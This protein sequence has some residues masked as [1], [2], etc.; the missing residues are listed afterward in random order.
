MAE[1]LWVLA[2]VAVFSGWHWSR[3]E[4][5][6][7]AASELALL[8]LL[9]TAPALLA[10]LGRLRQAAAVA[11]VS[12]V[13]AV[14]LAFGYLPFEPG[15]PLYPVR[16][17]HAIH[18]GAKSWFDTVTPFDPGRFPLTGGLVELCF[19]GLMA[20]FAWLL[21]DGRHALASVAAAFALFAIPSTGVTLDADG[22]RAAMF[23]LLALAILAVCQRRVP[24][25]G[26]AAGQLLGLT[27][28]TLVAGLV[29]GSAPGVAKG[30]FFDWR[31]WNPLAGEGKRVS[32]GYV[33]DQDYGP[34]HFPK[35]PTTV[36]EVQSSRPLYWKAEVLTLFDHDHWQRSPS[37][38]G[39]TQ[40]TDAI[41]IPNT[42]LPQNAVDPDPK[43][44]V[45]ATFKIDALAGDDLLSTGQPIRY[46][47]NDAIGLTLNTDGTVIATSD[48]P[49]GA[50]Y[51][52]RSYA[53]NP[54][55]RDLASAGDVFPDDVAQGVIVN[56]GL[57][58]IWGSHPTAA[59]QRGITLVRELQQ[60]SDQA[61]SASGA[62]G[63]TTEYG[64]VIALESYFR[65]KPFRYDQT[66]KYGSGPVL[67]EFML[68]SHHGY[69][70]MFAGSMALVLRM[71]GIPS[72]VAAGFTEGTPTSV[73]HY[74]IEDRDA[75]DWVEVYFPNYGWIPFEP[76]PTRSLPLQA[77]T[78]NQAFLNEVV[79][80]VRNGN[81]AS[82]TFGPNVERL[83]GAAAKTVGPN[84]SIESQKGRGNT[85]GAVTVKTTPPHH[86]SFLVWLVTAAA[87]LIGALALLK[88]AAVRWRYL[89]RGPRGQASAAYH[90]LSTYLGDQGLRVPA[91]ATFEELAGIAD[92]TWGVDASGLAAA[93]SAARYAPPGV[94]G[95]AGRDVRPQ[96]RQVRRELRRNLTV[97]ER[98]AGALR[99]RSVLAQTT[100]LD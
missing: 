41:G 63:A 89:R 86:R 39:P 4:R 12:V 91:N 85:G 58:P 3:M 94:A 20:L 43:T 31:H 56:G 34:L 83:I 38:Q 2:A 98:G 72:R 53:P 64:A 37:K 49:S 96:M 71:H 7:L 70:Q 33:W 77:S 59:E 42:S 80:D 74:K 44:V 17:G 46:D 79:R 25:G 47:T 99:V 66:P 61:W 73:G 84:G 48:L 14:W 100:H 97:R 13:G 78:A 6:E 50:T 19:F 90:E 18:D 29:V 62:D 75:H 81:V 57:V 15:H 87:I 67:A 68:H 95:R 32:V 27:V 82:A 30:A 55:P 8:T 52:V 45:Q 21:L 10:A 11:V 65:S 1:R 36:F 35:Q 93:G 22:L 16:I 76:T 24:L 60:A 23:L 28:A 9:A 40:T 26:M 54:R 88:L 51:T 92:S 69:C 5:P